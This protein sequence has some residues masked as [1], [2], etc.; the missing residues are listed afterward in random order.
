MYPP[1]DN[2]APDNAHADLSI[3]S[4][5]WVS[6]GKHRHSSLYHTSQ[7]LR[8]CT[9]YRLRV[10]GHPTSSKSFFFGCAGS[11][12]W[13]AGFSGCGLWDL[14]SLTRD[15]THVPCFGRQILNHWTT[16]EIPRQVFGIVFPTASAHSV[17]LCHMSVLSGLFVII[18]PATVIC[19]LWCP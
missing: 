11:L 4:S 1:P 14:S 2:G 3:E 19:D 8:Y 15:Q 17:S 16:R 10:C 13:P 18:I 5:P 6:I 12:L 7:I 9:F